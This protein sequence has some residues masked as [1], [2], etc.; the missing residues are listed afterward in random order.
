MQ[1]HAEP[2]LTNSVTAVSNIEDIVY[3]FPDHLK[4]V[5]HHSQLFALPTPH[6]LDSNSTNGI[7]FCLVDFVFLPYVLDVR[8]HF[9]QSMRLYLVMTE[10][11]NES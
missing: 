6:Q 5:S 8:A 3:A 9:S 1:I 11:L 2:S 10:S 7:Y 4:A